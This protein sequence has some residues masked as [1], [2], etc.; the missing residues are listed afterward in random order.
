M[1]DHLVQTGHARF[2]C[3]LAILVKEKARIGQTRTHHPFVATNHRA[4]VGWVDIAHQQEVMTELALRIQQRKVFL[5]GLHGQDE[6]FLRHVQKDLIE[7]THHHRRALYQC[8][9]LIQ[10]RSI[11]DDL[12]AAADRLCR[13]LQ[14]ARDFV[15]AFGKTGDHRTILAQA[16]CIVVGVGD[17]DSRLARFKAM[18]LRGASGLQTECFDR[19]DVTAMQRDQSVRRP[20]EAHAAPARQ[21][22]ALFQ[23]IAHDFRNRQFDDAL[24]Q[25]LLQPVAQADAGLGVIMEQCLCLAILGPSQLRQHCAVKAQGL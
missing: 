9:H 20:H 1:V 2:E 6:A 17:V 7:L 8:R 18:A 15:A 19:D 16:L 10:Q 3:F 25:R 24:L 5:V 11:L 14:L 4:A 12:D 22:A 21:L 23:L 13:G